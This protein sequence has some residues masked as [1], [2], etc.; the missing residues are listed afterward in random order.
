METSHYYLGERQVALREGEEVRYLHL[1]HL[2]GTSLMSDSAGELLSSIKYFPY[3]ATR[4][5]GV[6]TDKLLTGQRL[7]GTGLYYY[8]A[9]YYDAGLGRF[10]SVDIIVPDA[11][12][13]QSLNRYSYCL[14][15]PLKYVDPS[16]QYYYDNY[17]YDSLCDQQGVGKDEGYAFFMDN[18]GVIGV[19][20]TDSFVEWCDSSPE[21]FDYISQSGAQVLEGIFL[22]KAGSPIGGYYTQLGINGVFS[23]HKDLQAPPTPVYCVDDMGIAYSIVLGKESQM[24]ISIYPIGTFV[25]QS[26]IADRSWL[27][28]HEGFHYHEQR[29]WGG[30][31]GINW[32]RGYFL[33][34]SIRSTI[35]DPYWAYYTSSFEKR[36]RDWSGE[37]V[38][39]Y[40]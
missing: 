37:P 33:E 26:K 17:Y 40:P 31:L 7:D 27:I 12:N 14:S 10:I 9:R 24:G 32:Y 28:P 30:L 4:A 36:A 5:G 11:M 1:D 23:Y 38:Q 16:G 13:P 18:G 29:Q 8:N 20:D 3:G 21:P 2:T 34:K 15:N 25:Q 35:Y 6:A 19:V 22:S 39:P